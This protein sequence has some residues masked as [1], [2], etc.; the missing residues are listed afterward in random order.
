MLHKKLSKSHPKLNRGRVWC[1]HCGRTQCVDAAECFQEG[2]PKCCGYTM[3][4]DDPKE[5]G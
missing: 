3:T 1:R 4:L 2:W 5:V